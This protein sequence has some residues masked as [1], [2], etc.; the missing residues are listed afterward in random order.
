MDLIDSYSDIKHYL[1]IYPQFA[2]LIARRKHELRYQPSE[3]D[4]NSDIRSNFKDPDGNLKMLMIFE[5]DHELMGYKMYSEVI[6]LTYSL[7]DEMTQKVVNW[8]YFS[9]DHLTVDVI[10][11]RTNCSIS[12][13]KRVKRA[14]V[15][16]I[17]EN[18]QKHELFE[19][20]TSGKMIS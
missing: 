5:E 2:D 16:Q 20:F 8:F 12:T 10:S 7:S 4:D 19:P 13:V 17:Y 11:Q 1:K 14:F 3:P 18:L 9:G 6:R 15:A